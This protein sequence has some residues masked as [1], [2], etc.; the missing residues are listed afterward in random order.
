[1]IRRPPRSTLFPYTTL[2]RSR[3][4]A[5]AAGAQRIVEDSL[6]AWARLMRE[7]HGGERLAL[8][9]GVFM[10][11]KANGLIAEEP[12]LRDLFV[13]PSCGGEA[14][15]IR[16]AYPGWAARAG[17]GATPPPLRAPHPGPC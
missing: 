13:F 8:G 9:G 3:F 11:V 12:W 16:A 2:F 6:L 4:D 10:N 5:V 15:A 14:N 17:V 1:M 7:R